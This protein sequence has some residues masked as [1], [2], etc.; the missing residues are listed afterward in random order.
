MQQAL[1]WKKIY[2]RVRMGPGKAVEFGLVGEKP[3]FCLLGGPPSNH[4]A[5]LQLALPGLLKLAGWG[6]LC[7]PTR[8]VTVAENIKAQRGWT[9]FIHGRLDRKEDCIE[10]T[11]V[12]PKSR[13]QMIASAQAIIKMSEEKTHIKKGEMTEAYLLI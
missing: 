3:V 6:K 10:F 5:F 2:H 13:L 4:M 1:G 11:P 7:L 8:Q 12:K 9:D